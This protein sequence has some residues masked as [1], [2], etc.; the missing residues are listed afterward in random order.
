MPALGFDVAEHKRLCRDCAAQTD[1]L[2]R[3]LPAKGFGFGGVQRDGPTTTRCATSPTPAMGH[4]P[5][6]RIAALDG[7]GAAAYLRHRDALRALSLLEPG[8]AL[9]D[10]R[11][12]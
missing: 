11:P 4:P 1:A 7:D 5:L 2:S 6:I 9:V 8:I 10:A 12:R 3:G